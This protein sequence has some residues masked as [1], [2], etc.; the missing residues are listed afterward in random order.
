MQERCDDLANK[1]NESN[2]NIL[3]LQETKK[4]H[5]DSAY[6][7]KYSPRGLNQF[8]YK[9]SVGSSGGIITIWSGNAF[10]RRTISQSKFQLTVELK[11]NLSSKTIYI[12]N[13]YSPCTTE[14]MQEFVDWFLHLDSD[15][16]ELWMIVG[17]FNMI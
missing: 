12:T 6:I 11:C 16:Y 2:C 1:V 10:T 17:D 9:E 5:F 15:I 13:V 4:E 14:G 7:R 3:C 8:A